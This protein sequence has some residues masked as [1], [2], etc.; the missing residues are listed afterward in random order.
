MH[1]RFRS[2]TFI[3]ALALLA[4]LRAAAAEE[5]PHWRHGVTILKADAGIVL[6]AKD[7]GFAA[8][9]GLT[10]DIVPFNSDGLAL[11][12]LM[13]GELDSYE[14]SPGAPIIAASRGAD[15]QIVGC[16][17]PVVTWPFFARKEVADLGA[18]NGRTVGISSPGS[19]TDLVT[20]ALL[21]ARGISAASV[22]F[23]M[24]QTDHDRFLALQGG[25]I[26]AALLEPETAPM[27][28]Q[29]NM[30]RLAR[31]DEA[32]PNYMRNCITIPDAVL[33]RR[34]DDAAR[35]LAAEMEG[36]SYALTHRD[37]EIALTRK[38]M[39][40][41]DDDQRLGYVFD[42]LAAHGGIDPELGL[43][44][45][46]LAWMEALLARTGHLAKPPPDSLVDPAPRERALQLWKR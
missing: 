27:A 23:A 37:E 36:F 35:F 24:L 30:R 16:A 4:V 26:D 44:R 32:V 21:D 46:K 11:R 45:D 14:G 2:R 29:N 7:H 41:G 19:L 20:R 39:N 6:M 9:H 42:D 5:A 31:A 3:L 34:Q 17:G 38:A 10:L 40:I 15:L 25:I 33:K 43:P 28:E 18:L 22:R 12:A 13:A 8:R 1:H